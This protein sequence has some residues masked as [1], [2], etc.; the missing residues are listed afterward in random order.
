MHLNF[1]DPRHISQMYITGY[2]NPSVWMEL[3]FVK[4]EAHSSHTMDS[5]HIQ[6]SCN[7]YGKIN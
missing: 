7:I 4:N 5:F 1:I 3:I 6:Y 2:I